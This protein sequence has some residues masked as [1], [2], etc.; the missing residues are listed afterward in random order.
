MRIHLPEHSCLHIFIGV[1]QLP[2][3]G[4]GI[5][6]QVCYCV[7]NSRLWLGSTRDYAHRTRTKYKN[8]IKIEPYMSGG[9][10]FLPMVFWYDTVGLIVYTVW[11]R[12]LLFSPI[13]MVLV[14]HTGCVLSMIGYTPIYSL[15]HAHVSKRLVGNTQLSEV[16]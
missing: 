4:T 10:E 14:S 15:T 3:E 8:K 9:L 13:E 6:T 16:V 11:D 5:C 1:Q 7:S 12:F 2:H